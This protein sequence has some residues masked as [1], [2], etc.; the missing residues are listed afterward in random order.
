MTLPFPT[1][2]PELTPDVCSC[3]FRLRVDD[4]TICPAC[5]LDLIAER[6]R[7]IS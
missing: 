5:G 2:R 7:D 3:G 6:E 1:V 4:D